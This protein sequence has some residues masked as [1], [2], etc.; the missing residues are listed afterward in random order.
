MGANRTEEGR[1]REF[2]GEGGRLGWTAMADGGRSAIP[3]G[4]GEIGLVDGWRRW[5]AKLLGLGHEEI[6]RSGKGVV[7]A[8]NGDELRSCSGSA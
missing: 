7:G 8:V 4:I 3:A 2:D 1:E 6:E 5:R